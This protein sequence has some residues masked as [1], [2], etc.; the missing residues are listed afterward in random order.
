[1]IQQEME[2]PRRQVLELRVGQIAT[3]PGQFTAGQGQIT[4]GYGPIV[5]GQGLFGAGYGQITAGP[6]QGTAGYGQIAAGTRQGR[7]GYGRIVAE[8]NLNTAGQGQITPRQGQ[9]MARSGHGQPGE[10]GQGADVHMVE[11]DR[12]GMLALLLDDMSYEEK[13]DNQYEDVFAWD[14]PKGEKRKQAVS[15]SKSDKHQPK[16]K[17]PTLKPVGSQPPGIAISEED[18]AAS[19]PALSPAYLPPKS[20]RKRRHPNE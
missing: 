6:G 15:D 2:F 5:A 14:D 7:V 3:V 9:I 8:Q 10:Q 1:M 4:A 18:L 13:T 20:K 19:P 17:R 11:T 16:S 12:V